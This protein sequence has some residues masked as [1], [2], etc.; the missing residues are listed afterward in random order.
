MPW[1]DVGFSC[2]CVG[3][4]VCVFTLNKV[5]ENN[6]TTDQWFYVN[7]LNVETLNTMTTHRAAVC[8]LNKVF[9]PPLICLTSKSLQMKAS[10]KCINAIVNLLCVIL[11]FSNVSRLHK[12]YFLE[13]IAQTTVSIQAFL[14][15]QQ[16]SILQN[17]AFKSNLSWKG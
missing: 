10:D 13:T 4:C 11:M 17:L 1:I 8:L 12:W 14:I 3:V 6:C 16:P 2:V 9:N 7:N 15:Q 5:K